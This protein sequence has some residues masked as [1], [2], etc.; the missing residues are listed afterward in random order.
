MKSKRLGHLSRALF[1]AVLMGVLIFGT[2]GQ[3]SAASLVVIYVNR[4]ATGAN[5]GTSWTN[6]YKSLQTALVHT[7]PGISTQIWVAKGTYRPSRATS[8]SDPRTKTFKLQN[9]VAIYGGFA[10][11]ETVLSQRNVSL[12]QTILSGDIGT[13][14]DA[15]DNV[16]HVVTASLTGGSAVLNGF[17]I[18]DGRADGAGDASF[19]AGVFIS[20]GSPTLTNLTFRAN[21]ASVSGGAI[22]MVNGSPVITS[23]VF[24]SNHATYGGGIYG[25]ST[26]AKI[27]S[28]TFTSNSADADGGGMYNAAGSFST[29]TNVNF[30]ANT[31]GNNGAGLYIL[32]SSATLTHVIFSGNIAVAN[33]GGMYGT[34]LS[35]TKLTNSTFN[36][37]SAGNGGGLYILGSGPVSLTS[38][39]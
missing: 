5:N 27:S 29:L 9:D 38:M 37:N 26:G 15:T 36:G 24:N 3:A 8:L 35:T 32:S 16:Y 11:Y 1:S 14:G 6:A 17:M 4:N 21:V 19:G 34:D 20:T 39:T 22:Y 18:R 28:V 23:D 13:V 2:I 31:A 12:N 7:T 33:G 25:A 10:G 30:S